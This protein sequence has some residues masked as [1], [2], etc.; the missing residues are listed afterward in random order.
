MFHL[1][2]P[3]FSVSATTPR[4]VSVRSMFEGLN[5]IDPS[6]ATKISE[7]LEEFNAEAVDPRADVRTYLDMYTTA[8]SEDPFYVIDLSKIVNQYVKWT[9][10][11]P[12]VRPFYAVKCNPNPA[13]IK[14]IHAMGG[15]FDCA[16][17][18]EIELCM[19]L[20]VPAEDIIFANPCKQRNHL[21]HAEAAGVNMVTFDNEAEIIKVRDTAPQTKMVLR[22]ITDDSKSVCK[23]STKFGA[24]LQDTL[25]LIRSCKKHGL[26]LAGVSFHVGSGCGDA[27]AFAKAIEAAHRVFEEAREEGFSPYLLDIGG[28]WP[29]SDDSTLRFEDICEVVNPVLERLFS[30]CTVIAEPGRYFACSTHTLVA[31]VIAKREIHGA[32]EDEPE[33]L[34]YINDGVYQS[35]NCIIFDHFTPEIKTIGKE[36]AKLTRATVFGPTC[37][38]MDCI[39]KNVMMPELDV[40]DWVY[41]P[42]FGAYTLAAGSAF[43]GFGNI[44]THYIYATSNRDVHNQH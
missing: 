22:I 23:F 1:H 17:K 33:A 44:E 11:L 4:T 7:V 25:G 10:N 30:D 39:S 19:S 42:D 31:N 15:G 35:F 26:D 27:S 6:T 8:E 20:G 16:S 13:F 40:G 37:D 28:G 2:N 18:A 14:L 41:V 43:N 12:S 21:R 34:Y 9:E 29:G 24:R 3:H 38:S 32:A 36:G 5:K